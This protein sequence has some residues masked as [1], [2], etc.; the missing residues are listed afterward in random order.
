MNTLKK[1]FFLPHL[2]ILHTFMITMIIMIYE[3]VP[4]KYDS[5]SSAH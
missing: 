2:E 4:L 5:F 3:L 1:K